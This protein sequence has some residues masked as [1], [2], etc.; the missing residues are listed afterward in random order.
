MQGST[1]GILSH[2]GGSG[3]TDMQAA[4]QPEDQALTAEKLTMGRDATSAVLSICTCHGP[5]SSLF[6]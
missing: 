2:Q 4:V 1:R 6:C 3:T 5:S